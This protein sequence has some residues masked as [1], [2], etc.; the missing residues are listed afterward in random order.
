MERRSRF[1]KV[2]R[3]IF[4]VR[5]L[6]DELIRINSSEYFMTRD[7]AQVKPDI[8]VILQYN[9]RLRTQS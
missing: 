3:Q 7:V 6:L 2:A 1:D 9:A 4:V 5:V 8:D